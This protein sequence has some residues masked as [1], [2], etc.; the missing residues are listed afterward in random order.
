MWENGVVGAQDGCTGRYF[1]ENRFREKSG[2]GYRQDMSGL[3]E[4]T[5]GIVCTDGGTFDTKTK[6]ARKMAEMDF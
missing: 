2:I 4:G 1:R 6:L 3:W 5:N